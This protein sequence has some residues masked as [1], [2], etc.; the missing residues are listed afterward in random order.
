MTQHVLEMRGPKQNRVAISYEQMLKFHGGPHPGGVAVAFKVLETAFPLVSPGEPPER[1]RIQ[2]VVGVDGPGVVDGLECA[3]RA[4]SRQRAI[5]DRGAKKGQPVCGE[6]FYFEVHHKG[7]S[8]SLWLKDGTLTGEFLAL[9]SKTSGGLASAAEV[10]RFDA[11]RHEM[12][13]RVMTSPASDLF[14]IGPV[15]HG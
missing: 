8:V 9:A 1:A 2:V 4:F 15:V 10:A 3:T 13:E 14:E 6:H 12:A 5:I 7:T 11:L